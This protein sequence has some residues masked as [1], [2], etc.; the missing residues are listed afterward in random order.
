MLDCICYAKMLSHIGIL[1]IVSIV[2][3]KK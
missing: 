2:L 3:E 1:M